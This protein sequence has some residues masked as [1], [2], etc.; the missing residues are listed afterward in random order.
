VAVDRE[1]FQALYRQLC[2]HRAL[3]STQT[4]YIKQCDAWYQVYRR[5]DSDVLARAFEQVNIVSDYMP[6]PSQLAQ[7]VDEARRRKT[8]HVPS[9]AAPETKSEDLTPEQ[10]ARG[11]MCLKIAAYGIKHRSGAAACMAAV[12]V[13]EKE[14]CE[15]EIEYYFAGHDSAQASP[16][17]GEPRD[18]VPPDHSGADAGPG[19]G[20]IGRGDSDVSGRAEAAREPPPKH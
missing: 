1:F 3:D 9:P 4:R 13:L 12:E 7:A 20:G 10:I 15:H 18:R 11:R 16:D 5:E 6:H 19:S 2:E 17:L 14:G 8:A